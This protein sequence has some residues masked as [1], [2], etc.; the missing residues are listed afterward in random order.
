MSTNKPQMY[1]SN[2]VD[3]SMGFRDGQ[4]SY[5]ISVGGMRNQN[6]SGKLINKM[7]VKEIQIDN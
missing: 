5:D 2:G 1:A 3:K 4:S 7:L 6:Y